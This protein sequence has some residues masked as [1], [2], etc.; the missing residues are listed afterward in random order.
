MTILGI[1][2]SCD[3]TALA[4]YSEAQGILAEVIGSQAAQHTLY[5]GVVPEI[6]AR[7]HLKQLLPLLTRLLHDAEFK[8]S[9]LTGIAYTAGPGL[10]GAVMVGAAFARALAFALAIPAIG[11]HHIE[12]H[13]LSPMLESI[14]P[15]FPFVALI[16]SGG[17]TLLVNVEAIGKYQ[18]L[19][20]SLDDAAGEAFDK[21]AKLMGLDYPGGPEI[22]LRARQGR[23]RFSFSRPMVNRPG[24]DFSFSGLK[25]QVANTWASSDKSSQ[26]IA[27][28]SY[29]LQETI[30]DTLLIKA[31]RALEAVGGKRLVLVG[32]VSANQVIRAR[33]SD[34]LAQAGYKVYFPAL[35]HS[36]DNAAMIA[37]AGAKRLKAGQYDKDLLITARARWSLVDLVPL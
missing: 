37:Y 19:G 7:D 36:T 14:H 17:H 4:L 27:D 29:A 30:S 25:T 12:G 21:S 34:G 16:V 18:L 5:G 3:D 26:T 2:T 6:A 33:L 10:L 15:S 24:F 28:I 1:E 35:R 13:L 31:R 20:Q 22:E 23:P 9:D 32:G 8:L 11:I